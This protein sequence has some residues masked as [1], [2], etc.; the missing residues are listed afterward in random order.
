MSLSKTPCPL[1]S[2]GSN[3]RMGRCPDNGQHDRKIVDWGV[4]HLA[5]ISGTLF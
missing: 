5:L 4:K 1:V 2:T 3:K